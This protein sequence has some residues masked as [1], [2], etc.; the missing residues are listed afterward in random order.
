MEGAMSEHDLKSLSS[1]RNIQL[2]DV[3]P[4]QIPH[5]AWANPTTFSS[6][7]ENKAEW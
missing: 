6:S 7:T 1:P 4:S 3:D 5:V 2:Q